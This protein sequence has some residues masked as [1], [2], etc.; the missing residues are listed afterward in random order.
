MSEY[1]DHAK[2]RDSNNPER[3]PLT[4]CEG[5]RERSHQ[6]IGH[7][8]WYKVE[9]EP[10]HVTRFVSAYAPTGGKS[11][12]PKSNYKQQVR[13]IQQRGLRTNPIKMFWDDLCQALRQWRER[14]DRIILMMDAN[15]NVFNG[16]LKKKLKEAN[17]EMKEAVHSCCSQA[18]SE[19]AQKRLRPD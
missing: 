13:Y 18:R 12:G 9:G 3:S 19:N 10:G 15:N 1:R 6:A 4:I 11:S 5:P 8:T 7:W 17:I 14:G 16:R 2:R